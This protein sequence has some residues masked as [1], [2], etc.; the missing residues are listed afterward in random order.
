MP[1]VQKSNVEVQVLICVA[2]GE[3]L[4]V[5]AF[6]EIEAWPGYWRRLYL[7]RWCMIDRKTLLPE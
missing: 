2:C 1:E 6:S 4:P 5:S 3:E 7:C